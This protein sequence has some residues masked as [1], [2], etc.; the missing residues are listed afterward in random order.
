MLT[1]FLKFMAVQHC[2]WIS[3]CFLKV[4]EHQEA[5]V[6]PE[7]IFELLKCLKIRLYAFKVIGNVVTCAV[8]N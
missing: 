2:L 3:A 1:Q 7:T 5:M 6:A 4:S 8:K